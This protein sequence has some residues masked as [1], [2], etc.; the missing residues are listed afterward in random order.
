MPLI[1]GTYLQQGS[2][3][4]TCLLNMDFMLF[5]SV[6]QSVESGAVCVRIVHAAVFQSKWWTSLFTL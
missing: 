1:E 3:D 5:R 4:S 2:A 6:E